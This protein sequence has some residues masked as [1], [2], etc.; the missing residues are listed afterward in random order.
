VRPAMVQNIN[1]GGFKRLAEHIL[2]APRNGASTTL[3]LSD[4]RR[5]YTGSRRE[6]DPRPAKEFSSGFALLW[7]DS[8]FC[9]PR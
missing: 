7:R 5:P 6:T 9:D 2:G 8:H 3:E 1:A 4:N